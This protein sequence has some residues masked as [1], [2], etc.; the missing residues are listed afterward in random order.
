MDLAIFCDAAAVAGDVLLLQAAKAQLERLLVGQDSY[1][2]RFAAAADRFAE[3]RGWLSRLAALVHLQDGAAT[4]DVKKVGLF[5]IVHGAR[6]LALQHGVQE[7]GTA[8]RLARLAAQ[9]QLEPGLAGDAVVALHSLMDLRLTRQLRLGA[10][11]QAT[12]NLLD[13]NEL[14]AA[15]QEQLAAALAIVKRWRALLRQ[16]FHLEAL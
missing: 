12:V 16:H 9:D 5:P 2:A 11:A 10:Q 14:T 1:I 4:L 8:A 15:E 3:P 13:A 6:A 7:T